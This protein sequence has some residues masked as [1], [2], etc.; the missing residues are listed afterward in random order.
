MGREGGKKVGSG[1]EGREGR[2]GGKEGREGRKG[3]REGGREGREGGNM[4]VT[5]M[6]GEED[7][8]RS[9]VRFEANPH[10]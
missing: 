2:E 3:G 5:E 4:R 10:C 8:K 1:K 6:E 9:L 7:K